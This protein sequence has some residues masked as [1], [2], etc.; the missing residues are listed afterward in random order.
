MPHF[1]DRLCH[2]IRDKQSCVVVGLDPRPE[3]LPPD[4]R[5][6]PDS[7][8]E[9][10]AERIR[11]FNRQVIETV[12]PHAVAVKPQIAFYEALGPAGFSAYLD[13]IAFARARGLLVIGDIKR[14]DVGS[15]AE[16]YARAH[17][18]PD[19]ADAVTVNPYLGSDSLQP[20]IRAARANER[21]LFALVKTSN[22]SATEIQDLKVDGEP[23]CHHVARLVEKLGAQ[24]IGEC[25]YSL[26]GAVVGAT[27]PASAAALRKQM[28]HAFFLVPG[29]GAQGGS[30]RDC[31]PNFL[32]DGLGA[33]VNSSRGI[34]FAWSAERWRDRFTPDQWRLATE[35]AVVRMKQSLEAVRLR[36][37]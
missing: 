33:V 19:G 36:N 37:A 30:A 13:A 1:A 11:L 32:P 21:G 28:P 29:Y 3:Q 6:A 27:H 10:V 18:G 7:P 4:I 20:F 14:G 22:K 34:I 2:A 5:P 25:G 16:A 15:T 23:L 31:A 9:L 24:D 35:A 17:L 12:A 26:L 8:C